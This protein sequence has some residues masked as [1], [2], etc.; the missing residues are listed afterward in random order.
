MQK[1]IE[2]INLRGETREYKFELINAENGVRLFHEYVAGFIQMIPNLV[3]ALTE[4]KEG[5]EKKP[6]SLLEAGAVIPSLISFAQLK[7]LAQLLVAKATVMIDGKAYAVDESGFGPHTVGDP[8]EIYV[9]VFYA[10]RA[11]YPKYIDPILEKHAVP[12]LSA[13]GLVPQPSGTTPDKQ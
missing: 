13:L 6:L 4:T 7:E 8:L 3:E 1:K 5:E 10:L 12:F 2:G 9:D 11:N